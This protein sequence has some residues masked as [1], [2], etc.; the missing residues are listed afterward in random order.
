MNYFETIT[1]ECNKLD[2]L[3]QA[4]LDKLPFMD[5]D[6]VVQGIFKKAKEIFE[7]HNENWETIPE[8]VANTM[9]G[10]MPY[11]GIPKTGSLFFSLGFSV[12]ANDAL[13]RNLLEV[14]EGREEKFLDFFNLVDKKVVD[15]RCGLDED[16]NA[17][18]NKKK[19]AKK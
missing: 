3:G 7:S 13:L 19:K 2:E 11:A 14:A 5:N 8:W 9:D 18:I 15:K 10:W 4:Y 17:I 1:D 12:V 6:T 16:G